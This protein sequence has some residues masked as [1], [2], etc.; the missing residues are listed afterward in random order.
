MRIPPLYKSK[1]WQLLFGGAAIG[2]IISWG[3]F[4]HVY[5]ELREKQAKTIIEQKQEIEQLEH[6]LQI[7]KD[8]EKKRNN[9]MKRTLTIQDIKIKIINHEQY[10]LDELAVYSLTAAIRGDLRNLL[11]ENIQGVARNK[12]L[13]KKVIENK[14][15]ERDNRTYQFKVDTIYFDTVL[16]ITLKIQQKK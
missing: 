4:L 13:L 6:D 8:E 10:D 2:S 14:T 12:E 11:K 16:E 9:Q 15:Y 3:I 7:W 5:G 1:S